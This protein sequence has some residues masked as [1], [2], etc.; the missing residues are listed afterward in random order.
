MIMSLA[1]NRVDF[2]R[3]LLSYGISV[4]TI[5][6]TERLEF[7][8][9]YRAHIMD[10]SLRY[11]INKIDNVSTSTNGGVDKDVI[12]LLC[13]YEQGLNSGKCSIP[14]SVIRKIIKEMCSKFIREGTEEFIEVFISF[15]NNN[16]NNKY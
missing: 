16:N 8:Y 5:L 9:G 14:R 7:L 15:N 11:K 2:V 3:T 10:S 6:T 12:K 4:N 1:M 13:S